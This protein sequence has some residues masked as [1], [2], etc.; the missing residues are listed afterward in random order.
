MLANL[1]LIFHITTFYKI[2]LYGNTKLYCNNKGLI[3]RILKAQKNNNRS[4]RQLF[5]AKIDVEMQIIDTMQQLQMEICEI[6]H[7]PGHQDDK[8]NV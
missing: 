5:T 8:E 3:A 2:P 7:V 1:H 4:P 6:F